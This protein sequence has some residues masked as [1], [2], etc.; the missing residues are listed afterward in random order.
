MSDVVL[1]AVAGDGSL[2]VRA[3]V[4]TDLCEEA[5]VRHGASPTGTAALGRALT[6]AL[7]LGSLLKDEQTILLQWRGDGPLGPVVAEGRASLAVRGYAANPRADPPSRSGKIDVGGAVGR[8]GS[9]VVVKD[10]GLKAPYTSSVPLQSGEM[11]EDLAYY[12]LT[13]EQIPSAVGLGV[14]V[15]ADYTVAAAGGVLVEAL[16]GARGEDIDRA[17]E[18][19]SALGAVSERLREGRGG[20]GLVAL[21]LA[22]IPH[23]SF[24]LGVPRFSCTCGPERL[25]AVQ[26]ALA[27]DDVADLLRREGE[28][29]T[30][31]SF[32]NS[33]WRRTSLGG[34]WERA[35][36]SA[37]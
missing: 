37:A 3:A 36:F 32:C 2:L 5:Q 29:R 13:S 17:V 28:L 23:R 4:T 18:N 12:L 15:A 24:V 31:C 14:H 8:Q 11:G 25:E 19:L 33:Q 6:G 20:E 26:A 34:P 21:V 30:R 1:G 16:P 22:G 10:L 35:P 7:L 27:P 9:L